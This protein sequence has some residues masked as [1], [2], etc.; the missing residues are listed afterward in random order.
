[1]AK[2]LWSRVHGRSKRDI[3]EGF[4]NDKELLAMHRVTEEE[5][6]TLKTFVPF[7]AL[8]GEQDIVF[9]LERIRRSQKRW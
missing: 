7:G 3:W 5:I 1:M 8:T 2:E 9:I 4:I 6:R